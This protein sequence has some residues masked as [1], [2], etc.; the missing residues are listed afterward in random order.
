MS[1]DLELQDPNRPEQRLGALLC[2][3]HLNGTLLAEFLQA[4]LQLLAL[5]RIAR[6]RRAKEL[7]RKIRNPLERQL[8]PPGQRI[9][10]LQLPVV[11]DP[12]DV[13]GDGTFTRHPLVGH[14][15]E[16]IAELH[17]APAAQ[18]PRLHAG[19]I[20]PGADAEEC[21]AVAMLRV[22]VRL[23]LEDKAAEC[24]LRREHQPWPAVA[25]LRLWRPVHQRLQHF[26]HA[27][28][29]DPGAEEYR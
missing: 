3:N 18:V 22:H 17:V 6:P 29:V 11:I 23:D 15:G 4:L 26:L 14:E 12:D 21:D 7:R 1:D 8:V 5:H 9:A 20:A 10:N 16:R 27:E 13:P 24:G 2:R 25:R 19:H 28:I